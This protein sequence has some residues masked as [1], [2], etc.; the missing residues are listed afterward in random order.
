MSVVLLHSIGLDGR[1]WQFMD[2]PGAFA[3]DLPGHGTE[4]KF[5]EGSGLEG[6]AAR[7]LQTID[8]DAHVV[9]LSLG[10]AVA[11]H[12]A[13]QNPARVRSLVIVATAGSYDPNL[14]E[15]RA[16]TVEQVGMD[17]VLDETLARWFTST[18][19]SD[20]NHEGVAYA[21]AT[22]RSHDPS[23]FANSWR[24]LASHSTLDLLGRIQVPTTVIAGEQDMAT[25]PTKSFEVAERLPNSRFV[26]M[27]GPHML[28]LE[29]PRLL[30]RRIREHLNWAETSR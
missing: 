14:M 12:M 25:P 9:G 3:V 22:L 16:K 17:G 8:A 10:G 30:S 21:R 11:Q 27:P 5:R 15:A 4:P 29:R 18:A 20:V 19:L 6:M 2:V 24:A 26:T 28:Q 13:L 1:C 23:T 7:V